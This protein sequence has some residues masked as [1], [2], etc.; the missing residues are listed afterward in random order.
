MFP[1]PPNART[2]VEV[3]RHRIGLRIATNGSGV[4]L[5]QALGGA[6][7]AARANKGEVVLTHA[8]HVG[9]QGAAGSNT[10]NGAG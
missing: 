10:L 5:H 8:E 9:I 4:G 7:E 3:L 6:G 1:H 2:G